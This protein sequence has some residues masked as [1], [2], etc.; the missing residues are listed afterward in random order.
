MTATTPTA[1]GWEE[2]I[3]SVKQGLSFPKDLRLA[4]FTAEGVWQ[5]ASG[6]PWEFTSWHEGEPN[7]VDNEDC[8]SLSGQDDYNWM[9]LQCQTRDHMGTMHYAVCENRKG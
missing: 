8:L 5:W 6:D 2:W 1:T 3:S 4:T 7:N 9:D